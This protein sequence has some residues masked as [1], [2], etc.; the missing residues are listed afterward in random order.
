[1]TYG[2]FSKFQIKDNQCFIYGEAVKELMWNIMPIEVNG[3][4]GILPSE[5]QIDHQNRVEAAV[6][7]I[8]NSELK[9]VV[10]SKKQSFESNMT[11]L[12][13]L[14]SLLDSYPNANCYFFYHPSV[15][16]WMGATPE[17]LLSYKKS[18]LKT[19]SLAGT[20][21]QELFEKDG[22]KAKEIEEQKLVT[23]FIVQALKTAQVDQIKI[24][25]L[26]TVQ[27]GKLLHLKT[28]I[29]A[30]TKFKNLNNCI[31]QLHPT[32]AVCG[33]PRE[34]ALKYILEHENY[35]RS[36]YTGYL[37]WIDPIGQGADYYVNLR[38][39]QLQ[40][41]SVEL[42]AGGG[43]TALS[44]P[45]DEYQEVQNKLKTMAALL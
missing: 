35:D 31:E 42:Y 30:H 24:G 26:E 34:A 43:I 23:D 7:T 41:N 14:S 13:M 4:T 5:G 27:A 8:K 37:G 39:M 12:E 38:C 17:T 28:N 22:W 1:M 11:E 6:E 9:K 40:E 29:S 2:V 21:S 45:L 20:R 19:M 10:I 15:G 33:L 32:P 3:I 25:E 44:N 36:F 16:K 18:E